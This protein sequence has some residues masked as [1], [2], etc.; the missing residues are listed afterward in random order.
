MLPWQ[1]FP[2]SASS[3]EKPRHSRCLWCCSLNV[4]SIPHGGSGTHVS[5]VRHPKSISECHLTVHFVQV[6]AG[7]KEGHGTAF[8][9]PGKLP[10]RE[11]ARGAYHERPVPL[12]SSPLR[13]SQNLD[14]SSLLSYTSF[15]A[16]RWGE[17][18]PS[19][20]CIIRDLLYV[21]QCLIEKLLT[22][23]SP[24]V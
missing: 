17:G 3:S 10:L 24:Q 5:G 8:H 22:D 1:P 11:R 20:I 18:C 2:S 9:L 16:E 21:P 12:T 4:P 13:V 14:F 23:P 6:L 15:L 7:G 19:N